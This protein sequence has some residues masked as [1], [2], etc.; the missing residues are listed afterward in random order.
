MDG[1]AIMSN[2][3]AL[4]IGAVGV[5]KMGSIHIQNMAET[6]L[7]EVTAI[8]TP[9]ESEIKWS[10]KAVPEAT[11][12]KEYNNL[13]EDEN[14]D[15]VWLSSPTPLHKEHVFKALDAGKHIF[16]EKPLALNH[17]DAWA[18]VHQAEKYPHLKVA[19]GFPRRFVPAYI[20]AR[21]RIKNGDLGEIISIRNSSSDLFDPT[22]TFSNYIKNSGGIFLDMHIHCIDASLY[23]IGHDSE[24]MKAYA[25]GTTKI[26]PHFADYGDVDNAHGL[27]DFKDGIICSLYGS[28]DNQHGHQTSVE[29][30]GSK[31]NLTL[32]ADPRTL[33]I[34]IHDK[35][36]SRVLNAK[37]QMDLFSGAYA[38]EIPAFRDW[39][40]Y[41][42]EPSFNLRDA[43]KAVSIGEALQ[44]SVR[45]HEPVN[46]P[47]E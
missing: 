17:E 43:A 33:A 21:K 45:T 34:D 6:K 40:L 10:K 46:I 29:I 18:V 30:I 26:Y 3:S 1:N 23:L 24:P 9:F 38:S 20:E 22:D 47:I 25:T 28:R 2:I 35:Q 37:N 4:R 39:V 8:C 12:Y 14:V 15:V 42:K 41:D 7:V 13:L 31:G 16:C 5:G 27:V 19:C 11:V 36:G 32:H 44:Q